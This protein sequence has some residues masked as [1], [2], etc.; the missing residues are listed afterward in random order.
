MRRKILCPFCD[1][2]ACVTEQRLERLVG[3]A[4]QDCHKR[5][6]AVEAPGKTKKIPR[7]S[8]LPVLPVCPHCRQK[9]QIHVERIVTGGVVSESCTCSH[10]GGTLHRDAGKASA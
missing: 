4:C 3:Y 7:F 5:W 9:T 10:C 2:P 1:S 8:P 6:F